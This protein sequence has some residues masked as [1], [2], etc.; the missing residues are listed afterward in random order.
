MTATFVDENE[1]LQRTVGR[2]SACSMKRKSIL[3]LLVGLCACGLIAWL[4]YAPSPTIRFVEFRDGL[5]PIPSERTEVSRAAVFRITNDSRV[6][7]SFLGYGPSSPFYYYRVPDSSDESGWL[8]LSPRRHGRVAD[9]I[10]PHATLDL[11]V[12]VRGKGP[13]A[14]GIQFERCTAEQLQARDSSSP[15]ALSRF[16]RRLRYFRVPEYYSGPEPT[17]STIA[18]Q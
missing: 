2:C 1:A 18:D 5:Y 15:S 11:E 10:A 4:S 13:F 8:A 17:W 12:P 6:P 9:T 14:I 7:Y 16:I 3:L